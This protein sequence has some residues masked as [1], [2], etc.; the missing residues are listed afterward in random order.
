MAAL[1]FATTGNENGRLKPLVRHEPV[2][3]LQRDHANRYAACFLSVSGRSFQGVP[4]SAA[5]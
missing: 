3:D 1:R 2:A 4:C 5:I